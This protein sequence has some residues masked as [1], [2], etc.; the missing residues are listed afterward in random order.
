MIE[1][2]FDEARAIGDSLAER[3]FWHRGRCTWLAR[4]I[5]GNEPQLVPTMAPLGPTLYGGSGGVALFLARL[6]KASGEAAHRE[7]AVGGLRHALH[8]SPL[9]GDRRFGFHG[10]ALGVAWAAHEAA[11]LLGEPDLARESRRILRALQHG[12]AAPVAHDLTYGSAGAIPTLLR[13]GEA[14]LARELGDRMLAD[15]R[16]TGDALSWPFVGFPRDLAGF[17]HGASGMALAFAQLYRATG[18]ERYHG[19]ALAAFRHERVAFDGQDWVDLRSASPRPQGRWCHGAPGIGMA[20]ALAA[21]LLKE[22][23]LVEEL[24]VARAATARHAQRLLEAP[25]EDAALC[26][27]FGG[28]VES[29]WAMDAALGA[30]DAL[31]TARALGAHQA[32]R[33][34]VDAQRRWPAFVSWPTLVASGAHPG[35]MQGVAGIGNLYLRLASGG[36]EPCA[37][38]PPAP[39][40]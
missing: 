38:V 2:F 36:V 33:F 4:P 26:C 35:L 14:D 18:E 21:P 19:A 37:L 1:P 20:R 8:H 12:R 31:A 32:A 30:P 5:L 22:P 17:S 40:M 7:A 39:D 28:I 25:G 9:E 34:G 6:A 10:G 29:L 16:R 23:I 11:Q 13:L 24:R 27:G 15:A 3:A